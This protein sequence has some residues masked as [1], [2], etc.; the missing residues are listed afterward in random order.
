[1]FARETHFV[2]GFLNQYGP[3]FYKS[4]KDTNLP[5][6]TPRKKNGKIPRPPNS[7][8]LFRQYVSDYA[9]R[10]G[11][12]F[13]YDNEQIVLKSSQAYL[14]KV[15]SCLW[16]NLPI[17]TRLIFKQKS[18]T[19][20]YFHELN[21]PEYRYS[22]NRQAHIFKAG[23][24]FKKSKPVKVVSEET[25]PQTNILTPQNFNQPMTTI[26]DQYLGADYSVLAEYTFTAPS[27]SLHPHYFNIYN[28]TF[29]NEFYEFF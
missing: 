2:N 22:P 17:D 6:R 15:S 3:D 24:K 26:N 1:M 25:I 27:Q 9:K 21:Y 5:L 28:N 23:R 12:T 19:I 7:F 14:G 18:E 20:K 10:H 13:E 8:I 16:V 29:I 11:L 4:L